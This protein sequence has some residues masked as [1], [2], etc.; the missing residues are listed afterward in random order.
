[1]K[2]K[3]GTGVSIIVVF[4]LLLSVV[5]A[6]CEKPSEP[7]AEISTGQVAVVRPARLEVVYPRD[8]S[9]F[10]AELP[11]PLLIFRDDGSGAERWLA[12]FRFQDG[13]TRREQVPESPWRVPDAVWED[14]RRKG[15]DRPVAIRLLGV[16]QDAPMEALSVGEVS[17]A[18]SSDPVGAP[19]FYREV[20]LPFVDAVKDPSHILWRF[21]PLDGREPPPVV[22]AGLPVC[23]NCHSF[24][25]DGRVL[26]MDVDYSNDKGSYAIVDVEEEI[27]LGSD[28]I[29]TWSDYRREDGQQTFGLLSQVSPDGRHVISTVKDRS[30]FVPKPSLAYSQLFFPIQGVLAVYDRARRSFAALPGADDPAFVQS[31][32]AWSHDGRTI[33]FTRVAAIELRLQGGGVLLS[34]QEAADFLSGH[35]TFRYEIYQLPFNDGRGGDAVPLPGASGNGKSNYFPRYTPDGRWLV[36]CQAENFSLLQPDSRLYI[37]PAAGGEPR[38]MNC[39]TGNMNSWHTFSPNGRWMVFSSKENSPYTQLFIT[40]IDES[41]NDTP[42]VLLEYMT[43]PDRAANIPEFVNASS[44]A[45]TRISERF[46]DDV[47]LV[48]T[49]EENEKLGDYPGA[50]RFYRQALALNP[51]NADAY[52]RLGNMLH[53]QGDHAAAMEYAQKA[54]AL[55][56]SNV[57]A[58]LLMGVLLGEEGRLEEAMDFGRKALE[59]EP[60]N[61]DANFNLAAMLYDVGRSREAKPYFAAAFRFDNSRLIA[62]EALARICE[63]END[64]PGAVRHLEEAL[65]IE[66]GFDVAKQMLDRLRLRATGE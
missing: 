21:G 66:P 19:L 8:G 4:S 13:S 54:R 36:F 53:L 48:R 24:S 40:H 31:N 32:P 1:M 64:L 45:I 47:S 55:E 51:D 7:A 17:V 5:L 41:G 23:G 16:K 62:K 14:V 6:G 57:H 29:I 65:V 26:G 20:N 12:E 2:P 44:M 34:Q 38:L 10:P 35:R 27:S 59:I 43:A 61:P 25:A 42:A 52:M 50:E 60:D 39:N 58:N 56:P 22:L 15:V 33:A 28:R 30:V 46:V 37:V 9:L 18:V 11:P 49:G 3:K 63:E